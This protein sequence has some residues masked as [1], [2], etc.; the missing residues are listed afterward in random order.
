[1]A[2]MNWHFIWT[3]YFKQFWNF[4]IRFPIKLP[5]ECYFCGISKRR[6]L[7]FLQIQRIHFSAE[8][9]YKENVQR[10][11]LPI[12]K[13]YGFVC[14]ETD[15]RHI[16]MKYINFE[17]VV[18]LNFVEEVLIVWY[19]CHLMKI[20]NFMISLREA[21]NQMDG[22]FDMLLWHFT[23]D[24]LRL[25][26]MVY[27]SKYF[28][29]IRIHKNENKTLRK[30]YFDRNSIEITFPSHKKSST[31]NRDNAQDIIVVSIY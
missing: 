18:E 28:I 7:F 1:M 14:V 8:V 3:L 6:K 15:S 27:T 30:S 23:F 20:R 16:K 12:I 2:Q 26:K 25:I 11:K 4:H 5:D 9:K 19:V 31:N 21:I 22:S 17:D 10:R 24:R 29:S 13:F